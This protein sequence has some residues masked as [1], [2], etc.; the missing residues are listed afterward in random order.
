MAEISG[1]TIS[2]GEPF[3][4][5]E[6][7]LRLAQQIQEQTDLTLLV[8]SGYTLQQLEKKE[9]CD[10]VLKRIDGLIA[11]PYCRELQTEENSSSLVGSSNQRIYLF[12]NRLKLEDFYTTPLWE[13]RITPT[14][15]IEISG[16]QKVRV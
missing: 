7:L 15:T 13:I 6:P 16:R 1:V 14:G 4:Q 11:E 10:E 12:S 5:A 9:Y 8:Y 3:E 2:G